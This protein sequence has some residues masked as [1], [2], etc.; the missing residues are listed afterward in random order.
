MK[1]YILK[2]H[3]RDEPR[4]FMAIT[5]A[6]SHEEAEKRLKEDHLFIEDLTVYDIREFTDE[7]LEKVSV[8]FYYKSEFY[9]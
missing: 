2:Y 8:P 6:N 4:I 5:R 7:S 3:F 9:F 1:T